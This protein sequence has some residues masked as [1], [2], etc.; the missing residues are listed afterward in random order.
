MHVQKPIASLHRCSGREASSMAAF[1]RNDKG[2]S[3]VSSMHHCSRA[4]RADFSSVQSRE[5]HP[6]NLCTCQPPRQAVYESR[7]LDYG[8]LQG[9][10]NSFLQRIRPG[11]PIG[12]PLR[13]SLVN[14]SLALGAGAGAMALLR[15]SARGV[16]LCRART[17]VEHCPTREAEAVV[18]RT[19][20]A[21]PAAAHC[22]GARIEPMDWPCIA[23]VVNA[24]SH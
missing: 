15:R 23:R 8:E 4:E 7:G 2:L 5:T 20:L 12:T 24:W 14:S 22:R 3:R 13:G 19:L 10:A 1:S 18:R 9:T 21:L 16:L 17:A 6:R 11:G